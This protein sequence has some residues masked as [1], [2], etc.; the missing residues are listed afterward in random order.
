MKHWILKEHTNEC[1]CESEKYAKSEHYKYFA[2]HCDLNNENIL[3]YHAGDFYLLTLKNCWIG[4]CRYENINNILNQIGLK[5]KLKVEFNRDYNLDERLRKARLQGIVTDDGVIEINYLYKGVGKIHA[6][7]SVISIADA[8]STHK[9]YRENYTKMKNYLNENGFDFLNDELKQLYNNNWLIV[10]DEKEIIKSEEKSLEE[11]ETALSYKNVAAIILEPIQGEG[12]DNH[13]RA[14]FFKN[15]RNLADR[16]EAMLI[17]DE[18]QTGMGTTGK[19]WA[20]EHFGIIPDMICFG[21]KVQACGFCSTNRIDQV[22]NNVFKQSGRINSTW[23][24]NIV[25]MARGTVIIDIIKKDKLLESLEWV[26]NY[27][28]KSLEGLKEEFKDISNVRGRGL[29]LAFDLPNTK[30][31]D[32]VLENM[33]KNMLALPLF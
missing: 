12:G 9:N 1:I 22:K 15:I 16:Y 7:T 27:F 32:E 14:E 5:T 21:K 13:F 31:R 33:Q 28:L 26:G 30:R 6:I 23:G 8:I 18:V 17:L 3:F 4:H 2:R 20:Y 19:W 11:I 29:M 10:P 25:D 24:G